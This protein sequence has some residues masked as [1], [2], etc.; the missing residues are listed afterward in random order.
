MSSAILWL[1]WLVSRL[2]IPALFVVFQDSVQAYPQGDLGA[3]YEWA[4]GGDGLGPDATL[5]EYPGLA[6]WLISAV[7]TLGSSAAFQTAWILIMLVADALITAVLARR[8]PGPAW[9]WV[10]GVALLGPVAWLRL[11]MLLALAVV[12]AVITRAARPAI[13]G[14]ALAGAVLLKIW[15]LALVPALLPAARAR[16]WGIA[17]IGVTLAGAAIEVALR[18]PDA[19]SP[20]AWQQ[21]RGTQVESVLASG[22]WAGVLLGEAVSVEWA[23]R[24]FQLAGAS[25]LLPWVGSV[26][27]LTLGT[28]VFFRLSRLRA[29]QEIGADATS[30]PTMVAAAL[31]AVAAVATNKVFS[32]QYLLWFLPLVSLALPYL[33]RRWAVA[34]TTGLCAGLTQ[35]V[36]P[37]VYTPLLQQDAYAVAILLAR[38]SLVLILLALLLAEAITATRRARRS[39]W[40]PL[41]QAHVDSSPG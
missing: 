29:D 20:L 27:L 28:W 25:T 37:Y 13:S 26:V 5:G 35:S 11:E 19:L 14:A 3:Y 22:Q 4:S 10:L 12:L 36:F 38:N 41:E 8:G 34:V 23:F 18:G 32:P 1:V 2:G 6:Q 9:L 16:I 21:D 39:P 17:F 33:K 30:G 24:S 31:L 7:A 15:P 40:R